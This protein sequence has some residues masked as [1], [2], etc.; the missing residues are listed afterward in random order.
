MR[1]FD[2]RVDRVLTVVAALLMVWLCVSLSW[3][4]IDWVG[5]CKDR[6]GALV[7]GHCVVIIMEA[8]N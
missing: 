4:S 1:A 3:Y 6:N 5:R 7:D 2:Q 8:P